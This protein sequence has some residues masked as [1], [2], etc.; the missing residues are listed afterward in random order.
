MGQTTIGTQGLEWFSRIYSQIDPQ[1]VR[2]AQCG[3]G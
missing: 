3:A 1:A 2:G